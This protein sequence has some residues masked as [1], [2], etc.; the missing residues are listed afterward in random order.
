MLEYTLYH[1]TSSPIILQSLHSCIRA[2]YIKAGPVYAMSLVLVCST[3]LKPP[4]K[5]QKQLWNAKLHL[6]F[7]PVASVMIRYSYLMQPVHRG[8]GHMVPP[9]PPPLSDELPCWWDEVWAS[10]VDVRRRIFC[11]RSLNMEH[12]KVTCL[13][14]LWSLHACALHAIYQAFRDPQDA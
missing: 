9:P 6:K 11:N 13:Y 8:V 4:C 5:G 12:I 1:T 3:S 2:E 7:N 14:K 10:P